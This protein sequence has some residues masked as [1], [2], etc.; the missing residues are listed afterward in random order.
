MTRTSLFIALVGLVTSS[1]AC[2]KSQDSGAP[3]SGPAKGVA[4]IP[5]EAKDVFAQRCTVCHGTN[6]KGAGV[7]AAALD[8]KPRNYTDKVWQKSVT[9]DT[10]KKII[11]GGGPSVGKSPLMPANADLAEKPA[12]VDGL[13]RIIRQFGQ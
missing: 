5:Q 7:G 4:S 11:V 3:G 1:A 13:V 6:G 8:P 9:D 2:S 10:L 12:V